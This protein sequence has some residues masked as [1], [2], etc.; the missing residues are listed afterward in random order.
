MSKVI[1]KKIESIETPWENYTGERVEEFLKETLN[2]KGGFAGTTSRPINS[3]YYVVGFATKEDYDAWFEAT[4]GQT[5][6]NPDKY[7]ILYSF[8]IPINENDTYSATLNFDRTGGVNQ[9]KIIITA[10][11]FNIGFNYKFIVNHV[12]EGTKD[13]ELGKGTIIF[14]LSTDGKNYVDVATQQIDATEQ[15]DNTF[16]YFNIVPFLIKDVDYSLKVKVID[17]E[18]RATSNIITFTSII[19]PTLDLQF[20]TDMDEDFTEMSFV[21][22]AY[23]SMDCVLHINIDNDNKG[24]H[25]SY[26]KD[27][28]A[29]GAHE[30]RIDFSTEDKFTEGNYMIKCWLVIKNYEQYQG[31]VIQH[32]ILYSTGGVNPKIKFNV[33]TK[34]LINYQPVDFFTFRASNKNQFLQVYLTQ[35]DGNKI[36]LCGDK[37]TK[38]PIVAGVTSTIPY[39][40]QFDNIEE[41]LA[42]TL[43]YKA[44]AN[45][46]DTEPYPDGTNTYDVTVIDTGSLKPTPGWT[47][48][49]DPSLRSNTANDKNKIYN[50]VTGHEIGTLSDKF[51]FINDG[52][53]NEDGE[54]RLRV[55][56]G[57]TI[58]INDFNLTD[59]KDKFY[60]NIDFNRKFGVTV[61]IVFKTFNMLDNEIDNYT[62]TFTTDDILF[63]LGVDSENPNYKALIIRPTQAYYLGNESKQIKIDQD[64]MY[65]EG[66]KTHLVLNIYPKLYEQGN[67]YYDYCRIF[68]NGIINREFT[69]DSSQISKSSGSVSNILTIGNEN[70]QTDIDIYSIRIYNSASTS[71]SL[72]QSQIRNNYIASLIDINTKK[73]LKALNN[74]I[75][76]QGNIIYSLASKFYNTIVWKGYNSSAEDPKYPSIDRALDTYQPLGD[77]IIRVK[78]DY[79]NLEY[80]EQQD[81]IKEKNDDERYSG[82]LAGM[83]VKGQGA[84][85]KKYYKWNGQWK[86]ATNDGQTDKDGWDNPIHGGSFDNDGNWCCPANVRRIN[87]PGWYKLGND[88]ISVAKDEEGNP[89]P[90]L[91]ENGREWGPY[92]KMADCLYGGK[93]FCGKVNWASSMQCHKLGASNTFTELWKLCAG[94]NGGGKNAFTEFTV[95]KNGELIKPLAKTRVTSYD[96]PFLFFIYNE[97]TGAT[98]FYANM[99]FSPGKADKPTWGFQTDDPDNKYYDANYKNVDNKGLTYGLTHK[100]ITKKYAAIE[101]ADN[102]TLLVLRKIPWFKGEVTYDVSQESFKYNSIKEGKDDSKLQWDY[103]LGGPDSEKESEVNEA[104]HDQTDAGV[105]NKFVDGTNLVFTRSLKLKPTNY[106]LDELNANKSTDQFLINNREYKLWCTNTSSYEF[107]N[108]YRYDFVTNKWCNASVLLATS[109]TAASTSD[110]VSEIVFNLFAQDSGLG[111]SFGGV[112]GLYVKFNDEEITKDNLPSNETLKNANYAKNNQADNGLYIKLQKYASVYTQS[113]TYMPEFNSEVGSE[114]YFLD[115]TEMIKAWLISDFKLCTSINSN[116][117]QYYDIYDTVFAMM[118]FKYFAITDNRCKN[119][120]EYLDPYT[121]TIKN[122]QWDMDTIMQTDNTGRKRK[123]YYAEEHDYIETSPGRFEPLW[124]GNSNAFYDLMEIAFEDQCKTMMYNIMSAM[125]YGGASSTM[126]YIYDNFFFV[127]NYFPIVAY[128]E[129]TRLF[130]EE[131]F[132]LNK[133]SGAGIDPLAQSLGDQLQAEIQFCERREIY[134]A[135]WCSQLEFNTKDG[136]SIPINKIGSDVITFDFGV[137]PFLYL[138]PQLVEGETPKPLSKR[139]PA[140]EYTVLLPNHEPGSGTSESPTI[141]VLGNNYFLNYGDWANYTIP[142]TGNNLSISGNHL[143]SFVCSEKNNTNFY[144]QISQFTF[145]DQCPNIN[146]I[147]FHDTNLVVMN[148]L[149]NLIKLK[150]INVRDTK[151][152]NIIL[153]ETEMLQTIALPSTVSNLVLNN[154]NNITAIAFNS[155]GALESLSTNNV[156]LMDLILSQS[157]LIINDFSSIGLTYDASGTDGSN[158][159]TNL[160]KILKNNIW[161]S[162]D[163]KIKNANLKL[164]NSYNLSMTDKNTLI[165]KYG[166]IDVEGNEYL[167]LQY[168]IISPT[169]TAGMSIKVETVIS[170]NPLQVRPVISSEALVKQT[171]YRLTVIGYPDSCN[172]IKS[173]GCVWSING[174]EPQEEDPWYSYK[175][176]Y[177]EYTIPEDYQYDSISFSC[178]ISRLN[179]MNSII[180][181]TDSYEVQPKIMIDALSFENDVYEFYQNNQTIIMKFTPFGE[182]SEPSNEKITSLEIKNLNTKFSYNWISSTPNQIVMTQSEKIT[183]TSITKHSLTINVKGSFGTDKQIIVSNIITRSNPILKIGFTD[184]QGFYNNAW[185]IFT[186]DNVGVNPQNI[187]N[188]AIS[189]VYNSLSSNKYYFCSQPDMSQSTSKFVVEHVYVNS[190]TVNVTLDT[191]GTFF[192]VTPRTR[193]DETPLSANIYFTGKVYREKNGVDDYC[194]FG[195]ETRKFTWNATYLDPNASKLVIVTDGNLTAEQKSNLGEQITALIRSKITDATFNFALDTEHPNNIDILC[196]KEWLTIPSDAIVGNSITYASHV[197]EMQLPVHLKTLAN[198]SIYLWSNLKKLY[199]NNNTGSNQLKVLGSQAINRLPQLTE[200]HLSGLNSIGKTFISDWQMGNITTIYFDNQNTSFSFYSISEGYEASFVS[201]GGSTRYTVIVENTYYASWKSLIRTRGIFNL[202]VT[203][204]N[205]STGSSEIIN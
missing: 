106:R 44:Y 109:Q 141:I 174:I 175:D 114:Q 185:T 166:D 137:E 9:T 129:I 122:W 133:Y 76:G 117:S 156:L 149:T 196:S 144:C 165:E 173:K 116:I 205:K 136:Q 20:E 47:F 203:L 68:V 88:G 145:S 120:Y 115:L 191:S 8:P 81:K 24:I 194:E 168:R 108:V 98:E 125:L 35:P 189:T 87:A 152:T 123:P 95:N 193:G 64:V 63:R 59:S 12:A 29:A 45:N 48:Y 21:L 132:N 135:S 202:P 71:S 75:D 91:R 142:P 184:Q 164:D 53:V 183:G 101:G 54:T 190:T 34:S 2:K 73:R 28:A 72:N 15:T 69:I 171:K 172:D 158:K 46:D 55:P 124:S 134:I 131:S 160:V 58:T 32:E 43:T 92:Y 111:L 5:I 19:R 192:E 187:G 41:S 186:E 50:S 52:W 38:L 107:G 7:K 200:L 40:P 118:Y 23:N 146:N 176:M 78:E 70:A 104:Y 188:F 51:S 162:T 163:A 42:L 100:E 26:T 37:D 90:Q 65:Q 13:Y 195:S 80:D 139:A 119:T 154:C 177:C 60:P 140:K 33:L 77:L 110:S 62:D 49:L 128:N 16:T 130:Y 153:P 169:S 82:Y 197:I 10:D 179:G 201:F 157:N 167:Y 25:K 198:Y 66:E 31:K 161:G 27:V 178:A 180:L 148:G 84:T 127:Q 182:N 6:D 99:T 150:N 143:T 151:L 159:S 14:S 199:I 126:Q 105:F 57:H 79:K 83:Y 67:T 30:N 36:Y 181:N 103:D 39:K 97:D 1:D 112:Q 121:N 89:I 56:A 204:K 74:I 18:D 170:D 11:S 94:E 3:R 86:F 138:Y 155:F 85:A 96:I 4:E 102:D 22:N 113:F 61:E 93:K 17:N 147:D